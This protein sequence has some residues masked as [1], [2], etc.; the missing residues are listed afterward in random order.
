[1]AQQREME[2]GEF[3]TSTNSANYI[4][5]PKSFQKLKLQGLGFWD[6]HLEQMN[7]TLEE[8]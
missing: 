1:M 5:R 3:G 6:T 2:N 4:P 8:N 7:C